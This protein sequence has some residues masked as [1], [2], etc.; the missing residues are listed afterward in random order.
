MQAPHDDDGW[1]R[2][3]ADHLVE[4]ILD[5]GAALLRWLDVGLGD[6]A[7]VDAALAA[8]VERVD[9][10]DPDPAAVRA[11][12]ARF[13][14]AVVGLRVGTVE[15]LGGFLGPYDVVVA[16][17]TL[18]RTDDPVA[19]MRR[20]RDVLTYGSSAWAVVW[21]DGREVENPTAAPLTSAEGL[22]AAA[23]AAD[24]TGDVRT[25]EVPAPDG[26][27][28]RTALVVTTEA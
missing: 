9:A 17:L 12:E 7:L 23:G 1:T 21:D 6:G 24:W 15:D 26:G 22:G 3:L 18:P 20:M 10:V 27:A 5:D 25:L 19:A 13:D 8:G 2:Q 28:A 11:G 16:G 14:R 4:A